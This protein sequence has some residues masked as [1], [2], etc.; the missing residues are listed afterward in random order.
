[1]LESR[2]LEM[3][4]SLEEETKGS[5]ERRKRDAARC[6]ASEKVQPR[7]VAELAYWAEAGVEA[8]FI[9]EKKKQMQRNFAC[10][11]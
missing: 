10:S 1:M 6:E 8:G 7:A 4:R 11:E 5:G 2:M 3:E 9:V